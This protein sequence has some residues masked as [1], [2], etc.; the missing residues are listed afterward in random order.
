M[1]GTMM[2]IE[3]PMQSC[4]RT[5][6]GTPSTRNTSYSTGTMM[7]PP[8]MPN[9]PARMPID[10]AGD[11]QSRARAGDLADRISQQH[12]FPRKA[13]EDR[14]QAAMCAKSGGLSSTS[15]SASARTSAHRAGLDRL[16]RQM[17]AEGARARHRAEQPEQ[18][19]RDGV[20]PRAARQARARYRE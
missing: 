17:P 6:S 1:V 7:A 11:Q 14:A 12:A 3:V 20:Q 8:P 13:G 2:A 18:M 9:R 10:D 19:A 5:S 16:G 15:A 4:M